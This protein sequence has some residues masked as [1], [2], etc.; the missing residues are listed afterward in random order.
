MEEVKMENI[1]LVLTILPEKSAKA[2]EFLGALD[3]DRTIEYA[4]SQNRIGIT[5]EVWFISETAASKTLIA[6]IETDSFNEAVGRFSA[7]RDPFDQWFKATL[8]ECTGLDLNDPPALDLPE[9]VSI[10]PQKP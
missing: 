9:A 6:Y 1:C 10:F 8:K 2:R 4:N 3:H 7:S 5:K